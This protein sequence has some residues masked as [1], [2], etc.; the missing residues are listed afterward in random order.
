MNTSTP[1]DSVAPPGGIVGEQVLAIIFGCWTVI[2]TWLLIMFWRRRALH[3]LKPRNPTA[4]MI[5]MMGVWLSSL[6]GTFVYATRTPCYMHAALYLITVPLVLFIV[7][8]RGINL[9]FQFHHAGTRRE[10]PSS[11][12]ES[13][14]SEVSWSPID[15]VNRLDKFRDQLGKYNHDNKIKSGSPG[16]LVLPR[17]PAGLIVN[18]SVGRAIPSREYSGEDSQS[19]K[20]SIPA[21]SS[22]HINKPPN[23]M[24]TLSLDNP[25]SSHPRMGSQGGATSN[26]S[27]RDPNRGLTRAR[28]VY[29]SKSG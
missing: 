8:L 12:Q 10:R 18:T 6:L 9:L 14:L 19:R 24:K 25:A 5:G 13:W 4:V 1:N 11:C 28:S 23:D 20:F 7:W 29:V 3:P 15:D 16:P 2:D 26:G 22:G 27:N 21:R 17:S